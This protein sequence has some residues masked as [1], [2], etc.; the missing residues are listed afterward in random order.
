MSS[1]AMNS[2]LI[3]SKNEELKSFPSRSVIG[4]WP[5]PRSIATARAVIPARLN[6]GDC[7]TYATAA[8]AGESLLFI[9][10]DFARTDLAPA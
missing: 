10:N 1:G 5:P 2:W 7:M 9:G 6:L 4:R 8:V 3:S